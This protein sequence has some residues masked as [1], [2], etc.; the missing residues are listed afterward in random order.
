MGLPGFGLDFGNPDFVDYAK[1][2]GASGHRVEEQGR[3]S[4]LLEQCLNTPGV[5]LI[6]LPVDYEENESVLIKELKG[7]TCLIG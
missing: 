7:K 2:Y 6:E 5:H 1:S 4:V 3:L